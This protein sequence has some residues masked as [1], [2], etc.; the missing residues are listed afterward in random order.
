M[1]ER[2][3][4]LE[5]IGHATWPSL[6]DEWLNGW[7]LRA[8]GGVTRRS[9]SANPV[10]NVTDIGRQIEQTEAWFAERGL[11]VIVRL[12]E[13]A[14]PGIDQRLEARGYEHDLGA[15]IMTRPTAG[16]ASAGT[17]DVQLADRPSPRWMEAAA[18]EPGRG[19]A[20]RAVLEQL[21]DHITL[22][23]T[24]AE[25]GGDEPEAIGLGVVVDNHLAVFMMRTEPPA[26]RRGL[27]TTITAALAAWGS[28][29]RATEAVLQVH[30]ENAP[31]L[32]L[33]G[34]LGFE[35]QYEY[36]YR[37]FPASG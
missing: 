10:D 16:F 36:W 3:R 32:A 23:A 2:I 20:K 37:Q 31:A 11:P 25:V 33:Y 19:G 13:A 22:P 7:L 1:S 35:K 24:Y 12:T 18:R 4:Q 14:D 34:S 28:D 5:Q 30:P 29:Q 17:Q 26:R 15:I 9:N 6:E 21:L 8:G 27:A